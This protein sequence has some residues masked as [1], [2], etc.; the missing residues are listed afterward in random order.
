MNHNP[1]KLPKEDVPVILGMALARYL[2]PLLRTYHELRKRARPGAKK[3]TIA[4]EEL[5]SSLGYD[6]SHLQSV[7]RDLIWFGVIDYEPLENARA[8]W[9]ITI[10]VM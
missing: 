8:K 7:L 9:T 4:P 2:P 6:A 3:V 5:A 10:L 1:F